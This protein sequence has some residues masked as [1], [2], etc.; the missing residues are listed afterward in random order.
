MSKPF[1]T[2]LPLGTILRNRDGNDN[3]NIWELRIE[4]G[5][6]RFWNIINGNW[7]NSVG[8][9]DKKKFEG[10]GWEVCIPKEN[11]VLKLLKKIDSDV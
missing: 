7:D 3:T 11:N 1:D 2:D 6:K 8:H 5:K 10:I 4:S 9:F